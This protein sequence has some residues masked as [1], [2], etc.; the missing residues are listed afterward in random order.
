MLYPTP[1]NKTFGLPFQIL[2]GIS[3]PR[4]TSFIGIQS[5]LLLDFYYNKSSLG[6]IA[7]LFMCQSCYC[8][9][10]LISGIFGGLR[11]LNAIQD[12]GEVLQ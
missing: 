5:V 11:R 7:Y 10:F 2:C 9:V 1:I 8:L 4:Q 3:H 12:I 6:V